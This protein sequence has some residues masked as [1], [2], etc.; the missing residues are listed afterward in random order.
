MEACLRG[1]KERT[2]NALGAKSPSKVR[3]LPPPQKQRQSRFKKNLGFPT[4]ARQKPK[5]Y[6]TP[7]DPLRNGVFSPSACWP[8]GFAYGMP[9]FLP[10]P[11]LLA[12]R[13]LLWTG[14]VRRFATYF[15]EWTTIL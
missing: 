13:G 10:Q 2:A 8:R 9:K 4:L 3:I 5:S 11:L 15:E 1:R 14:L 7:L 12:C 6:F